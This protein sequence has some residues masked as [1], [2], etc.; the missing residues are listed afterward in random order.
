MKFFKYFCDTYKRDFASTGEIRPD[1][2]PYFPTPYPATENILVLKC[3]QKE[4]L[5]R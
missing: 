4:A 3:L 2:K 5:K 1:G